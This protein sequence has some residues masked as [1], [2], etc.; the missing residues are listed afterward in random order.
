MKCNT[1]YHWPKWR[2]TEKINQSNWRRHK[3]FMGKW[4]H[5]GSLSVSEKMATMAGS[6][7]TSDAHNN[8]QPQP[9]DRLKLLYPAVNEEETPLP[10][11]WSPKDKYN[12]IGL[13]QNNLRVHYK[14]QWLCISQQSSQ[15]KNQ[16]R[17][18]KSFVWWSGWF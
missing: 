10:K 18:P 3:L 13:S 14:G 8:S 17:S 6:N 1:T 7:H 5:P 15:K 9:P 12:F 2:V 4:V 11:S 16:L